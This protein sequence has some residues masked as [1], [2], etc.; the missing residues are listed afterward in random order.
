VLVAA[1]SC[2]PAADSSGEATDA[3]ATQRA[4]YEAEEPK[5]ILELQP[6]RSTARVELEGPDRG[7]A[8]LVDLNPAAHVW[9]LLSLDVTG[10]VRGFHLE[11]PLPQEQR[12]RLAA[13]PGV[14]RIEGLKG[15]EPCE[16]WRADAAGEATSLSASG[17]VDSEGAA[18][19]TGHAHARSSLEE[20]ARSGLPYAPLCGGRLYLRNP[21]AGHRTSLERITGFL[22]D[23]VYGGEEII[24]FVKEQIYR[25]AFLEPGVERPAV[26][27]PPTHPA[28]PDLPLAAA[29]SAAAATRCLI[30]GSFGL[31]VIGTGAGF[32]PGSWYPVRDLLG[33]H[34][35]VL[36]PGDLTAGYLSG[37]KPHVNRLDA[38][39][40]E[41]LIYLVAFDLG[42][43]DLRFA[44]GTDHPRLDWSPRPPESARNPRLPGP[45]GVATPAPLVLNGL[46]SPSDVERV[47]ATFAGGFKREHGAFRY[48]PLALVNHGSHYGFVQ[49]GAILSKLQPGLATLLASNDGRIEMKT[50]AASDD[51]S[52]AS[53]R[54]ARQNGVPLIELSRAHSSVPGALVN[55]WGPGNWSGS[56]EELLR[57]LR[58]GIC[59][60]ETPSR[61]FL[62]YGYFS[63]ATPSAMARVFQAYQCR[64]AMQL[65]MN[66][67][68]H[69]YLALNVHREHTR[70]IEHLVQGM[71]TC[72][73]RTRSGLAPRFLAAPDDRDFFYLT[74]RE[75]R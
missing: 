61:R 67:L 69:T 7:S 20:A 71:E 11:N 14:L 62:L 59:L 34:A 9:F 45:D 22:R 53:V 73:S 27:C 64:Y 38:I 63:A 50:W 39:E 57:T 54:Y 49:E 66:A 29:T 10:S 1:D 19:A 70:L 18:G 68:E 36:T 21:V 32:S 43:F 74:R 31:D 72:D 25:D 23:H 4:Q 46:V 35:S 42:E 56:A 16:V 17:P 26:E 30:P 3:L 2:A 24:S 47:V 40:T 5:S 28:S 52:L 48:G 75:R 37:A 12:P 51:A 44:L 13:G 8:T 15:G 33:V 65:D 55:L 6:F 58:A 60:Q 41:A